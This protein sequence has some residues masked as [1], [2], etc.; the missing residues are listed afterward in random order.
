MKSVPS[1]DYGA[2]SV[3]WRAQIRS[4]RKL[5]LENERL[6]MFLWV[7]EQHCHACRFSGDD[8]RAEVVPKV[9]FGFGGLLFLG[10][11]CYGRPRPA[12]GKRRDG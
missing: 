1:S 5:S 12:F 2:M 11:F 9:D 6:V 8:K 4:D 3:G 10:L 7:R